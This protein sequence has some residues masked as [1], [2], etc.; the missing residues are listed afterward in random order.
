MATSASPE[1]P[2]N[3]LFGG[4]DITPPENKKHNFQSPSNNKTNSN[5]N[6][7]TD[8]GD[9]HNAS[10]N[11]SSQWFEEDDELLLSTLLIGDEN[12]GD[13]I[14]SLDQRLTRMH[15]R[16]Q[17]DLSRCGVT[18]TT[19]SSDDRWWSF[20]TDTAI[21]CGFQCASV[22]G[23]TSNNNYGATTTDNKDQLMPKSFHTPEGQ[24]HLQAVVD[25]LGISKERAVKIT[26]AT[27]RT[28]ASLNSSAE[29]GGGESDKENDDA[30]D[31][32]DD[33]EGGNNKN[34][35]RDS[36]TDSSEDLRSLLGTKELFSLVLNRNRR[37][38]LARLRIITECLRL[39]QEYKSNIGGDDDN[40]E[41]DD[42]DGLS[43]KDHEGIGKSCSS[44]LDEIDAS[45]VVNGNKRGLFQLLLGLATGPSLPGLGDG[46]ELPYSVGKLTGG[47][48]NQNTSL[49]MTNTVG[50]EESNLAIRNEAAEA[51]LVLLYDRIDNG[52]QRLDLFLL[53]EAARCC[54]EF[55]FGKKDNF[56]GG[57]GGGAVRLM[58]HD[59][60]EESG[61]ATM[62]KMQVRLNGIW[63]LLCSECMGLW[64]TNNTSNGGWVKQHPFF[65][66]LGDSDEIEGD[67]LSLR[68]GATRI[69]LEAL[70]LKL[71]EL[72]ETVRDRRRFAYERQLR[73]NQ[74]AVAD[75]GDEL[76]GIN[77]PDAVTLLSFGLLLR[78]AHLSS[79]SNEFLAKLGGWG[80]ECAQMANDECAAFAY[81]HSVM[82][83]IVLDPLRNDGRLRRE[84]RSE[85]MVN[86]LIARGE[87][88]MMSSGVLSL[89]DGQEQGNDHDEEIFEGFS[90]DAAS[91]VYQ[92]IGNEIL[93]GTIR[94]FRE[95]LLSL[96]CSSAVDNIC[97]LT[98]LASVLYRNSS[99]LCDQF[100]CDW[101][102][103]CQEDGMADADSSDDPMCY[104]LDA[105][106]SLAVSTL[107]E[108]N[109][110]GSEKSIIHFLKPLSSFLHLIASMCANTATV[111][112][113]LDSEFLPEG[114]IANS[115]SVCVALAP[116][117]S[118]LNAS[119]SH[120][121]SE[122]RST[123]RLATS[124]IQSI[125][126]IA[127]FGGNRARDWIRQSVGPKVLC[128]IASRVVPQRQNSM[129][130][131]CIEL[132][133]SSMNL[134]AELLTDSDATFQSNALVCFSSSS[135]FGADSTSAFNVLSSGGVH[136][137]AT[138]S[139]M[140]V[141]NCLAMNLTRNTFHSQSET[142]R[143]VSNLLTVSNGIKVGL[144]VLTTLFS[145]GDVSFPSSDLQVGV[146][147]AIVSSVVATLVGLKPI[148][149]L[150]EED[151]V[152]EIAVAI[153]D[154]LIKA[155]ATST[156][157]GQV[158]AS[159]AS[160]PISL[161]LMKNASTLQELSQVM[162]SAVYRRENVRDSGKYGPWSRFVTPKRAKQNRATKSA[163][164]SS[165]TDD[166]AD[167]RSNIN[168]LSVMSLSLLLL[169]GEH[170]EDITRKLES[171]EENLLVL[172]PCNLLLCKASLPA[173]RSS[174]GSCIIANLNLIS[175]YASVDN[176][177]A[178]GA[179]AKSSL[180]SAK[181][182][183]MCLDHTS[184][185]SG[186]Y[187]DT[188]IGLS[189]F[190]AALGGGMTI[191]NT[192]FNT[193]YKLTN[194]SS[195]EGNGDSVLLAVILLET[196]AISVHSHPELARSMLVGTA[197]SQNWK[198]IDMI[199]AAVT[200]TV[201]LLAKS[202]DENESVDD[203]MFSL[204]SFLTCGCLH[205]I[206]ALWK[207]CRLVCTQNARSESKHACGVIT[208]HLAG[209]NEDSPNSL[210]ANTVVE[211]TRCSLLATM[212]LQ[213]SEN[214]DTT[215]Y[216]T[217]NKKRILM[218]MLTEAL[219]IIAIETVTRIQTKSQGGISF[220]EDLFESGPMECWSI[221][222]AS[223]NAAGLAA[224]S[225]LFGFS[226]SVEKSN[227][228]NWN[229]GSFLEAYPAEKNVATSTWCRYGQSMRLADALL[230]HPASDASRKF[231]ECYTL[232]SSI[233]AEDCFAASWAH[234]FEVV[235]AG[236]IK[237]KSGEDVHSL[238]NSLT[239][240]SLTALSSISESKTISES[241]L[242][243]QGLSESPDTK[244]VGDLSSLLLYSLSVSSAF[245]GIENDGDRC[246]ILLGMFGRL[247]ES[248]NRLFA[249]TQLGSAVS[250]NQV[251]I[252]FVRRQEFV[253]II[254]D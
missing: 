51:L 3:N 13:D 254:R 140:S 247:Y 205:V 141:L 148:M 31:D 239:E 157:L 49:D 250:S 164:I 46:R 253:F 230:A 115:M 125:S 222:L 197:V 194:D 92:S 21:S 156:A 101:E 28:F 238:M 19:T 61:V 87:L 177:I 32:D 244:P 179:K 95:A 110:G 91:I 160:A 42:D 158:V 112:S 196:V 217:V 67:A 76:W 106:H 83:S 185:S 116:L 66:G 53:M 229:V 154:E 236:C 114:L 72:G 113:I 118:S 55:E 208:S 146:C 161:A 120:I 74:H 85:K 108:L 103:F 165:Y 60:Q 70:C 8:D 99:I 237:T 223:N 219:E 56:G 27:L 137:E 127:Y 221:L 166:V 130:H 147:H 210:I 39:E 20:I 78:L 9:D 153:R 111:H 104:L 170:A 144:E 90:G 176:I 81:L 45:L 98:N 198:L 212:S 41:E 33:D 243:S 202:A 68:L 251:R 199:A 5:T 10:A 150:H 171:S 80:Q 168:E 206:S 47:G 249:M 77:A 82:D 135:C 119:D 204:R 38:F 48:T 252:T 225:W 167:T 235:A 40:E 201:E 73:L 122:E 12:N 192:L 186:V 216:S 233:Q 174:D 191:F 209:S 175:R 64:R 246:D 94:S 44:L 123:V 128:D 36:N 7:A 65:A 188:R 151:S 178:G 30:N 220:V 124:V 96:Q 163:A 11:K 132:A 189:V 142:Q 52:V 26:L 109:N 182:V 18:K 152:R 86:D 50:A 100:W 155:L 75:D 15:R 2:T 133:S 214:D 145:G 117:I 234:F 218:D 193:F 105:S 139:V 181:L 84:V 149:Y 162:D 29:E 6:G 136:S 71:R 88:Q 241:I 37:Q 248:A 226:A 121:T 213:E 240:C 62:E 173:S 35:N 23:N 97:M 107:V 231:L 180:L 228:R 200:D 43:T 89:T 17:Q 131:D 59:E 211:L 184:T 34:T 54:P 203:K 232:H 138:L 195:L 22:P 129:V 242:S 169:W 172:S 134:L 63:S 1:M 183:K 14:I 57:R 143:T 126:T 245:G 224:S 93:A 190:R 16:L 69:E 227:A 207:S 58:Q 187:G 24:Q 159:L 215:C 102:N 4:G 79:P 25:L